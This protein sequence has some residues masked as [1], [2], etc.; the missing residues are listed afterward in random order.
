MGKKGSFQFDDD[1][2]LD[3]GD[4]MFPMDDDAFG[5]FDSFGGSEEG[6]KKGFFKKRSQIY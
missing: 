2:D 3:F 4:E 6:G 1:D 5:D